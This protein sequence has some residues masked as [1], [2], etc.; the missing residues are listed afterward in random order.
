M[1]NV[2]PKIWIDPQ[3]GQPMMLD[4]VS[5]QPVVYQAPVNEVPQVWVDPQ[6]GQPMMLDPVSGQ[7]VPYVAPAAQ[8]AAPVPATPVPAAQVPAAAA[9]AVPATPAPVTP[10]PATPVA[11][12][13]AAQAPV[14]EATQAPEER[15]VYMTLPPKK[16]RTGLIAGLTVGA[17]A[18]AAVGFT[19]FVTPGFLLGGGENE[20]FLEAADDIGREPF[21]A[22]PLAEAPNKELAKPTV[23]EPV[24]STVPAAAVTGGTPGLYGGSMDLGVCDPQGIVDF[25]AGDAVKAK[26]WVDAFN[27]DPTVALPNGDALTTANIAQYIG[28]LTSVVLTFDTRVTNHGFANGAAKPLQ[29]VLQKGTAVL[30]DQNGVPRVKCYCGNPL[31]PAKPTAGT[32]KLTGDPWEDFDPNEVKVVQPT[33]EPIYVFVLT[34]IASLVAGGDLTFLNRLAG[35]K[36]TGGDQLNDGTDPNAAIVQAIAQNPPG[37]LE[38]DSFSV[39]ISAGGLPVDLTPTPDGT[40]RIQ[41]GT[42]TENHWVGT[43]GNLENG[44]LKGY[45]TGATPHMRISE[46]SA[47]GEDAAQTAA[48]GFRGATA[49]SACVP[50]LVPV[51]INGWTGNRF[52]YPACPFDFLADDGN[53]Y[54]GND[55]PVIQYGLNSIDGHSLLI[56]FRGGMGPEPM[57]SQTLATFTKK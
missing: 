12:A 49:A 48:E 20:V 26:A 3:T 40:P 41:I 2:P 52:E 51:S 43:G 32:P 10:A 29:A 4:P 27:A 28:S 54:A 11:Q 46:L 39:D 35:S 57:L 14:A 16:K 24:A 56:T 53:W 22:T 9:P 36:G 7:P 50:T 55:T 1:T 33:E 30:V 8:A 38:N 25:L 37:L 21:S 31:I 6:S 19:G 5:G 47:T 15:V 23:A 45:Y 18:I 17:V 44:N 34:D 13:P 42:L